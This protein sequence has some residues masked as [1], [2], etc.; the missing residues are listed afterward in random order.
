MLSGLRTRQ[1]Y[2]HINNTNPILIDGSNE[3]KV[4]AAGGGRR[5]R[6]GVAL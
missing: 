4:E 5:G 3:K 6:H 1:I 2:I